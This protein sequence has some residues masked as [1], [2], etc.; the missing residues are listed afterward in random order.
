VYAL[1]KGYVPGTCFALIGSRHFLGEGHVRGTYRWIG[2]RTLNIPDSTWGTRVRENAGIFSRCVISLY[3]SLDRGT[4]QG[5]A[6]ALIGSRHFLGEGHVRGT[7]RWI[8]RSTLNIS[9]STWGVRMALNELN[10]NLMTVAETARRLHVPRKYAARPPECAFNSM[11]GEFFRGSRG[12][13]WA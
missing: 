6:F 9:E 4:S 1:I 12:P 7:Y 10:S 11:I 5:R 2:R 3:A 13:V 8:T